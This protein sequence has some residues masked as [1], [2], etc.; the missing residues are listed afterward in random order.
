[1]YSSHSFSVTHSK[2][3]ARA[4]DPVLLLLLCSNAFIALLH[5]CCAC[6]LQVAETLPAE[7]LAKMHAPAKPGEVPVAD[8][9]TMDAA[10][11]FV[12]GFPTR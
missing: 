1:M 7:V 9:F 12:F 8:P 5:C 3:T 10:D 6:Y 2:H 4:C 11:G